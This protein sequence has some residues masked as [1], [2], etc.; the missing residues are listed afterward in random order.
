M[1]Y[2]PKR[3]LSIGLDEQEHKELVALSRKHKVSLA[4]LTRKAVTDFL[5]S[6]RDREVE[7]PLTFR[8]SRENR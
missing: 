1:V 2:T 8:P 3:R 6:H 5:E 4:W 7:L